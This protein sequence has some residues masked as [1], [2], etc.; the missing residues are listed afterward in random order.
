MSPKTIRIF[1]TNTGEPTLKIL[2]RQLQARGWDMAFIKAASDAE[3]VLDVDETLARESFRIAK[4]GSGIS[5]TGGDALGLLY[6]VGKFLRTSRFEGERFSPSSWRGVST[7][8]K[9]VRGIYF[10]T[11]FHN[12]YQDAPLEEVENYIEDIALWGFNTL[13]VWFDM[14][15]YRGIDDPAAQAMIER[16]RAM[17]GAARRIGMKTSITTLANEGFKDS[18][19]ALRA[20]WTAGHGGYTR[21]P[22]GH[23]HVELCPSQPGGTELIFEWRRQVYEAFREFP[24]GSGLAYVWIWPYDQGGCTCAQCA[25]WG[26]NGFLRLA[27]PLADLARSYFPGVKVVLSTWYFD[28]FTTGEWE[29][30][31][32]HLA[33]AQE[34]GARWVDYLMADFVGGGYPEW[35]LEHGV[36]GG[37]PLLGFPE[38]SMHGATPW[39]G[40]GANPYPG[41]IRGLFEKVSDRQAGGF[42]YSEGIFEDMNKAVCAQLYWDPRRS[43]EEILKEYIGYEFS[44]KEVEPVWQA[45]GLLEKSLPRHRVDESGSYHDYPDRK[46]P[47]KGRQRFILSDPGSVNEVWRLIQEAELGLPDWAKAS[48]R[49][50]ILSLRAFI[51]YDLAHNDF[52]ISDRC[53]QAFQELIRIYYAQN[54]DYVVSPPTRESIQASRRM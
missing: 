4:I 30:L 38:I 20:D 44:P 1:P 46:E 24:A 5:V 17:L 25:P 31:A 13:S 42:P 34:K 7:P 3:I 29:G 21:E 39:G 52:Y 32:R 19:P 43:V 10:A 8:V 49:W 41:V 50:R 18:P 48:W 26:A 2:R 47:W 14:H 11:H 53:E 16:L 15:T 27:H 23:Y 36:P 6:G 12:F 33:A 54:A 45:I 35:V 51:D 22:G 28:L 40:F 9:D 37:L